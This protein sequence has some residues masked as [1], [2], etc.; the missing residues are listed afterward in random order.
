MS[1][2][3]LNKPKYNC[4]PSKHCLKSL[5]KRKKYLMSNIF[6][7]ICGFTLIGIAAVIILLPFIIFGL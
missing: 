1:K 5:K 2:G 7:K 6:Y 4:V 3:Y